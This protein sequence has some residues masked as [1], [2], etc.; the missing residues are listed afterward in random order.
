MGLGEGSRVMAISDHGGKDEGDLGA[1][2]VGDGLAKAGQRQNAVGVGAGGNGL[3]RRSADG[4]W[5]QRGCVLA[6]RRRHCGM[7]WRW[8]SPGRLKLWQGVHLW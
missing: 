3:H 5:R 7:R 8:F 4:K 6:Q 2:A 1:S